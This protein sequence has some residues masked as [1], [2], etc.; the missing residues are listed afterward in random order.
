MSK[1]KVKDNKVRSK[2]CTSDEVN[3]LMSLVEKY[4]DTVKNK[5]TDS[6]TWKLEDSCR[7]TI[8]KEFNVNATS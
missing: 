7:Q 6:E 2:K 1:I 4:K 5:E 3:R 8:Q